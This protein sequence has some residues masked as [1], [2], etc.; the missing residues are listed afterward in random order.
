MRNEE[1]ALFT[2]MYMYYIN[3][4]NGHLIR[5]NVVIHIIDQELRL[6]VNYTV[7][8]KG[9]FF[10]CVILGHHYLRQAKTME[11]TSK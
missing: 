8:G 9:F 10:F 11:A 3:K 1:H 6:L 5:Q 7:T 4:S 2:Y